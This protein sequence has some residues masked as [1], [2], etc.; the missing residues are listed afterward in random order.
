MR[1]AAPCQLRVFLRELIPCVPLAPDTA[2]PRFIMGLDGD[3]SQARSVLGVIQAG[4]SGLRLW[5]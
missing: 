4:L 5:R 1:S 3:T 2:G